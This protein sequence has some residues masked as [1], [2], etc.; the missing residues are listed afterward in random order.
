MVFGG[1]GLSPG[2]RL[3]AQLRRL[4]QPYVVAADGGAAAALA[5]GMT[6]DLVIGDLDSIDPGTLLV[7][8]SAAVPIEPFP[9]D[10]DFSDGQL[11]VERALNVEPE[12]LLLLGFLGGA[13]LDHAIGNILL[14]AALPTGSVLADERNEC[15][16]LR[17][18]D[19]LAWS[20]DP[21][22][23]VSLL[24]IGG[25]ALGVSTEGLRWQLTGDTLSLGETRGL[26]NEP[27]AHLVVVRVREGLLLVLR[28]F[29]ETPA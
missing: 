24:P 8:N 11:A 28:H 5:F 23:V 27:T 21:G 1:S 3:T 20:P 9:R 4:E 25:D 6:P 2:P 17:G 16:L 19:E 13:R 22:E 15:R 12:M 7:L 10:K 14:L 29:V 18:G 26:S